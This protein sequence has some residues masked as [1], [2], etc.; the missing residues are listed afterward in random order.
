MVGADKTAL[1]EKTKVAG[2]AWFTTNDGK[3]YIDWDNNGTL[4]RSV[5][6]A[7]H[8]DTAGSASSVAWSG[9]TGK[10]EL[11]TGYS[12]GSQYVPIYTNASGQAVAC[13]SPSLL[14]NLASTSTDTIFKSG[15]RPGVTGILNVRNGGTGSSTA[16]NAWGIIYAA[17]SSA[18]AS[19]A[20]GT[21]GQYLKSN[22]SAAPAWASFVTPTVTWDDG[23]TAGPTLKIK[24]QAGSSSAAVAI[25]S[26]TSTTSGI[27]TI[28][29]Q[30][31]A[32]EKTF[33]DGIVGNL[34]GNVTGNA[35]SASKFSSNATV[36]VTGDATGT[37]AGSTKGWS[38]PL[39][40]ANSG[41][42]EGT[43]GTSATASL[44]NGGSFKAPSITVDAKGRVT[45]ASTF[46]LTLP[47]ISASGLGAVTA[48]NATGTAPL[49]LGATKSGTTVS[50]TGSVA[51][52]GAN[53]VGVVKGWHRT[54]GKATGTQ[55][56]NASNA[57]AIANRS[58]TAG[59][60]YGVETDNTGAMFV[61]VPWTDTNTHAVSSVN[62]YTG[63]V[64]LTYSDVGAAA[65]SHTHNY[66]AVNHGI[67]V[68]FGTTTPANLAATAYTGSAATVSRSDH[69]HKMPTYSDVGAAAANHTHSYAAVNHGTHVTSDT[70]K[71]ALGVGS[72]TSKYL[73]EDGTWVTPPNTNTWKANS[74]SSEGYVAS[75]SGQA[76]KVWKTD[77]NG[78]PAWR[79]DA[80]TNT[81]YTTRLYAGASGA[82]ANAAATNPYLKV[83]DDNTYRNQIQFKGSGATT[84]S[85]D[86]NG[87]ITIS[88]TDT[89]TTY[90]TATSST[91]G[92]VKIGYTTSGKNYAVQLSN[93]QM[94]VN[95]PWTDTNTTYSAA[96]TSA[97][98]LMSASDKSKLDGITSSADSVS[99]SRSLTSG[100]KIG[101]ITINGTGT[102]LYC[103]TNTNTTYSAGT[104]LSLSG[105]KFSVSTVPV[106]NGGTGSTTA[107]GAR[108][109]L[110]IPTIS[111]GTS[112]P[113]G[114][115]NGDIYFKY[116]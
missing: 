13:S 34:T 76:N 7:G 29:E 15:P 6:N 63:T 84:V 68:T 4:M 43:Y 58:T 36:A 12:K 5:L 95:V 115:S 81:H 69:V 88:S 83:T 105:T 54:S 52:A 9:V 26:A 1:D 25:P 104:G 42:T 51:T 99:F 10:P 23:T 75:G 86:A 91:L 49:T 47:T 96:T 33:N 72:G 60:Y 57:P 14:V 16:P 40:L 31:F 64:T 50:I 109:N 113:S 48:V 55:V 2:Y 62:G 93:G 89:N 20:A 65:A 92:L 27:V 77:A 3:F 101:T 90:S 38:V 110:G 61:N 116:S 100:T 8:A 107:S 32:G 37:S 94:Y 67:H 17:S 71:S 28:G 56:T 78:N 102:D 41:V 87:V 44:T 11:V 112:T 108:S 106:A 85:S 45:A 73:R 98:G 24:G 59:R 30:T 35:T 103:Q 79:D 70:V 80:N 21:A 74:S 46:T 66:A 39:T 82:A 19:T 111:H 114:G 97:A 22:G 53:S 18:Y